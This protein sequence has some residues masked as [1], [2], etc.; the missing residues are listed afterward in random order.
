LDYI[1]VPTKPGREDLGR[2]YGFVGFINEKDAEKVKTKKFCINEM[3]FE[4]Y[5][6]LKLE[7]LILFFFLFFFFFF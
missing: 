4:I 6:N 5:F 2:G 3:T 1:D 7:I